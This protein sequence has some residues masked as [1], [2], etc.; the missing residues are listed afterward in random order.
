[1]GTDRPATA[2]L[3]LN[4]AGHLYAATWSE[5]AAHAL[6]AAIRG[7]VCPLPVLVDYRDVPVVTPGSPDGRTCPNGDCR[8]PAWMHPGTDAAA[9]VPCHGVGCQCRLRS[10]PG[11]DWYRTVMR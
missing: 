3:I 7:V 4:H 11:A 8:H 2:F 6:G 9:E 10:K 1:M 5:P